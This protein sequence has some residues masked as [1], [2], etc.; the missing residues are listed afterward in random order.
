VDTYLD[1]TSWQQITAEKRDELREKLASLPSAYKDDETGEEAKRFD[2]LA[3]RLQLGVLVGD[4]GYEALQLQVQRIA[5]DL[6]DPTVLN[7]PVVARHADF[8]SDLVGEDW[9]QD[10]TL[11]MLETMRRTMRG[12]IRLIPAKHRAIVYA[13]FEDELGELTHAE[14]KGLEIGTDR[15]K[16]ERKVRTYLRS[17]NDNLVVQKLLRSR[18][19]TSADLDELKSIFLD[20]GFGTEA[21]IDRTAEEHEGFGL[22]LRAITGLSREASVQ[23]F[24][25]FQR[26]RTLSPA[27][28]A[29]VDLLI[30]SLSQNGYLDVGE[31]YEPPFKRVGDPD[32]IFRDASDI[33]VIIN[34]LELVKKT[35]VPVTDVEAC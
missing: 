30:E 10:A 33:D 20:L 34:V 4:P 23:A 21:D 5:E 7:N 3:L 6:L 1:P 13:D 14:L 11:S 25:A 31:L 35:A 18:Q 22:F 2:L 28:Y 19:I 15:T 8:L 26:G 12:L 17:H 32:I 29:F 27:E 9:W 16:F 24:S